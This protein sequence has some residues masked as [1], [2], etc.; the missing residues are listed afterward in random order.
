MPHILKL[1]TRAAAALLLLV[2]T[3]SV[4]TASMASTGEETITWAMSPAHAEGPDGRSWVELSAAPGES[5]T[6]HLAV[7]NLSSAPATFALSAADGYFTESGRFTMLPSSDTSTKSGLWI[8]VQ[9]SVEVAAG[10]TA[11][12]PFTVTVPSDA[13]PGDHPAGIAA[14]VLSQGQTADGAQVGVESRIG[15]R[16]ITRVT[17]EITPSVAITDVNASYETQWRPFSPGAMSVEATI[18]NTGNVALTVEGAATVSGRSEPL[19]QVDGAPRIEIFPGESRVLSTHLDGLWPRGLIS[20]EVAL[21]GSHQAADDVVTASAHARAW[22]LPWPQLASLL[23]A[24]L[25]LYAVLADRRR[26]SVRLRRL[27]EAARAQ[28]RVEAEHLPSTTLP[29]EQP[30]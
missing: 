22:A 29:M 16:V 30:Q 24:A 25:L 26:R 17:G 1:R 10:Q 3:L 4:A 5:V 7:R 18:T 12:V 8:A 23:G 15:F 21:V 27:L 9:E 2:S 28:G 6:E 20:V 19:S 11:V 14:S 13:S